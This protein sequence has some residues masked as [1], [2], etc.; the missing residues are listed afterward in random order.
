M[1]TPV[2]SPIEAIDT[3]VL[4]GVVMREEKSH[5]FLTDLLFPTS[6]WLPIS[7]EEVQ[8]DQDVFDPIM[9]PFVETNGEAVMLSRQSGD[10]YAVKC[11]NIS[12]KEPLTAS[13]ELLKR[14]AG[15]SAILTGPREDIV[16]RNLNRLIAKDTR[17]MMSSVSEREEWMVA[18]ML[19]GAITY[20]VSNR[21]NFS[22]TF[23]KPAGNTISPTVKWDNSSATFLQDIQSVK[24]QQNLNNGPNITDAICSTEA[25]QAIEAAV[26]AGDLAYD[27]QRN[28]PV[29]AFEAFINDYNEQGV[30]FLG[31]IGNIRFWEYGESVKEEDRSTTEKLIRAGYIEFISR[32]QRLISM[33]TLYYGVILDTEAIL[34]DMHIT[35]RFTKVKMQDDPSAYVQYMKT[36]PLPVPKRP[37]WY[38]SFEAVTV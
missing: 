6:T 21:A 31:T 13:A 36:R 27:N 24:R 20:S 25:A 28:V 10:T 29:G 38:I 14:T 26:E 22:L 1:P 23:N 7:G 15:D 33:N 8:I 16:R 9:A 32:T 5:R 4:N 2:N 17:L 18:Q 19:R 37:D 3:R 11:P 30:I 34:N 12:I 35:R